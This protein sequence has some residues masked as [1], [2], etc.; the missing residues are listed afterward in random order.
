MLGN[1]NIKKKRITKGFHGF[2]QAPNSK[3]NI[4]SPSAHTL[5][6]QV[7]RLPNVSNALALN[8]QQ[9]AAHQ[10]PT[11]TRTKISTNKIYQKPHINKR[12]SRWP[13][14]LRRGSA[15]VRLLGLWVRIPPGHGFFLSF[16]SVMCWHVE[17][18][19][20]GLSL[21]QRSPI[22][23]AVFEFDREAS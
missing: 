6:D 12:L 15:A 10:T 14:S 5:F 3:H 7:L 18:S 19:A 16:A 9:L 2:N 8:M 20:S 21:V 13:R 17:F 23:C 22:E 1:S 11:Q 4:F